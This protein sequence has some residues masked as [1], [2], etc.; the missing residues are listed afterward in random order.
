MIRW[1]VWSLLLTLAPFLGVYAFLAVTG[2][3][4]SLEKII[5]SGQLFLTCVAVLVGVM[6]EVT[7][8][9]PGD[10]TKTSDNILGIAVLYLIPI[11]FV[12]AGVSTSIVNSGALSVD[13]Q[14]TVTAWSLVALAACVLL[15]LLAVWVATPRSREEVQR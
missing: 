6:R 12:Y 2:T 3:P 4:P 10:R 7:T 5:G 14:Q 8:P 9:D 13:V 15:A 11:L 1:I